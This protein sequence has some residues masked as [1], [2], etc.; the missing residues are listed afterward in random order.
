MIGNAAKV[1]RFGGDLRRRRQLGCTRA[2]AALTRCSVW[3]MS[4]FHEKNRSISA[5]AAAGDGPHALEALHRVQRLFDR[6]RDRHLHLID[7][8]DAVI[9]AD[10]D[11]REIGRRKNG[12]GNR[13]GQIDADRHKRQDDEDDR[14]AVARGPMFSDRARRRG[15]AF[16]GSMLISRRRSPHW[17]LPLVAPGPWRRLRVP[18]RRLSRRDRRPIGL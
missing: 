17:R 8:R 6:P 9:D 15:C 7:R 18:I 3:N 11:A 5:D 10:D 1:S 13:R 4:T 16:C 14:L 12:D 2:S